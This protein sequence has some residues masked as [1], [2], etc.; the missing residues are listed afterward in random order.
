MPPLTKFKSVCVTLWVILLLV[1][2]TLQRLSGKQCI[3]S[4]VVFHRYPYCKFLNKLLF[5]VPPFYTFRACTRHAKY[6]RRSHFFRIPLAKIKTR[7]ITYFLIT[8]TLWNRFPKEF[9]PVAIILTS[10]SLVSTVIFLTY[11]D[12]LYFLHALQVGNYPEEMT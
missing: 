9:F 11:P 2:T 4:L 7:S 3:R 1:F 10:S 8:L 5:L 6:T 12:N